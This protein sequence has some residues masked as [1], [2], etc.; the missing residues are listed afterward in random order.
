MVAGGDTLHLVLLATVDMTQASTSQTTQRQLG[1]VVLGL[2]LLLSLAC[3]LSIWLVS[4]RGVGCLMTVNALVFLLHALMC[5]PLSVVILV[6]GDRVLGLLELAF[7]AEMVAGCVC[8]R[9][10]SVKIRNE[11]DRADALEISYEYLKVEQ[12]AAGC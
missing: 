9:I 11:L 7:T 10:Y 8:C 2:L 4:K 6:G 3:A 12:V 5:I 1:L